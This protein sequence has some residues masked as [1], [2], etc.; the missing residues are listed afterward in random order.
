MKM[1]WSK[2]EKMLTEIF[3]KAAKKFS[4]EVRKKNKKKTID[5]KKKSFFALIFSVD[6]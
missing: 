2:S 3:Q 4:L 5:S 6:M 1:F